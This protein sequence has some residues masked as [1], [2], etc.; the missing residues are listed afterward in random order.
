MVAN[1]TYL[2]ERVANGIDKGVE[3]FEILREPF[4]CIALPK[5]F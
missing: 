2:L 1:W 3:N 5:R 4:E